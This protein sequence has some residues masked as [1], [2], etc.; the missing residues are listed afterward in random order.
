M[1][2]KKINF[3]ESPISK[4]NLT[5]EYKIAII[6]EISK[7]KILIQVQKY[8]TYFKQLYNSIRK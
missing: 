6:T 4:M 3:I 5:R 7:M 8:K 2:Y 1:K